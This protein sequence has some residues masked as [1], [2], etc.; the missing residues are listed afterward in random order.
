[1]FDSRSNLIGV[2]YISRWSTHWSTHWTAHNIPDVPTKRYFFYKKITQ[3]C[4]NV[5]LNPVLLHLFLLEKIELYTPYLSSLVLYILYQLLSCLHTDFCLPLKHLLNNII[6]NLEMST[7]TFSYASSLR[8]THR[9]IPNM[10]SLWNTRWL[11]KDLALN[12][13][14]SKYATRKT[15]TEFD[16]TFFVR[17]LAGNYWKKFGH[18]FVNFGHTNLYAYKERYTKKCE[19]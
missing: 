6:H 13:D 3:K 1:M 8:Y 4:W 17:K 16:I 11:L 18:Q 10:N 14:T 19:K 12:R 2:T 9:L 7:G 5:S 15:A